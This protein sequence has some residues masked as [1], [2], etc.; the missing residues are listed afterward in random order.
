MTLL[1]KKHKPQLYLLQIC[2]VVNGGYREEQEEQGR[3]E[4]EMTY[5]S[6][7]ELRHSE[8]PMFNTT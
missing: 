6:G 8:G 3:R 5:H 1:P 4:G 2:V 7:T